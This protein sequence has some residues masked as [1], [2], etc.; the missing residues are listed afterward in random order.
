MSGYCLNQLVRLM[1]W[2]I[3]W[4]SG[5]EASSSLAMRW[6][7]G[8]DELRSRKILGAEG[9]CWGSQGPLLAPGR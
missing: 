4:H 7:M 1:A 8:N 5:S 2:V 3:N 9:P 6:A